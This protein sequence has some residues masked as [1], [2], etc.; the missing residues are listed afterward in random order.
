M[1]LFDYKQF[2][3]AK[4]INDKTLKSTALY[5]NDEIFCFFNYY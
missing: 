2:I 1:E 5:E 3:V 4:V